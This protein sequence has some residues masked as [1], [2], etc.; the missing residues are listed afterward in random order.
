MPRLLT[1]AVRASLLGKRYMAVGP[2]QQRQPA[3]ARAAAGQDSYMD[4]NED[5]G[6]YMDLSVLLF[7]QTKERKKERN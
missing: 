6:G 3:A 1:T 2:P 4:V 7:P 5:G